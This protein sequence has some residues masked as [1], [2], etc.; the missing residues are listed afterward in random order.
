M[1]IPAQEQLP[2]YRRKSKGGLL[3]LFG[4]NKST[5]KSNQ[6]FATL[7]GGENSQKSMMTSHILESSQNRAPL[8]VQQVRVSSPLPTVSSTTLQ[9]GTSKTTLKSKLDKDPLVRTLASWD[10]PE[11][12]KAYP[13]AI[14]HARLRAPTAQIKTILQLYEE[15]KTANLEQDV[16]QNIALDH[17]RDEGARK[18]REKAKR[19]RHSSL[20]I[21]SKDGWVEKVYV[22]ATSGYLLEYAGDGAFDRLPEKLMHLGRESA[23]FASDAITGEHWVLQVSRI[24][25]D[26]GV[27]PDEGPKSI[28]RKLG[29]GSGMRRSTS[30]FLLT[31]DS[32]EDM[33]SW[34]VAIRK[35]IEALGGR[36]YRPDVGMRRTNDEI[37]R[38]LR[39]RPS[40]RYFIQREPNHFGDKLPDARLE[41][42]TDKEQWVKPRNLESLTITGRKPSIATQKSTE[43]PS[44][45]NA[46]VSTDQAFLERLKETPRISYVSAGTKTWS[47]SRGSSPEP[48]PAR[49]PF[50]P[51][52]LIPK[53]VEDNTETLQILRARPSS[54]RF[55]ASIPIVSKKHSMDVERG[56][57]PSRAFSMVQPSAD[58][59][60]P[61]PLPNFNVPSFSKRYSCVTNPTLMSPKTSGSNTNEFRAPPLTDSN[62]HHKSPKQPRL[63]VEEKPH[64]SELI[65]QSSPLAISRSSDIYNTS[66]LLHSLT[67]SEDNSLHPKSDHLVSRRF[68]SLDYT[69]DVSRDSE[70]AQSSFPH[71]PPMTA[72]PALP[73]HQI[74]SFSPENHIQDQRTK[75]GNAENIGK[76][77]RPVSMQVH[78]DPTTRSRYRPPK[79]GLQHP[80]EIDEHSLS[81]PITTIPKPRRAPPPPP[82][83]LV[84]APQVRN[85]QSAS[86]ATRPLLGDPLPELPLLAEI[87]SFLNLEN[88][89]LGSLE[90]PWN[91]SYA[92]SSQDM[93]VK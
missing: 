82:L 2:P 44:V 11:L 27:I 17:A 53:P 45:S 22:L 87:P 23:A 68:S 66:S 3:W 55:P 9:H 65:P 86:Q 57:G 31:F 79:I 26:D 4:R 58:R 6:K 50:S 72:L 52:D 54:Q 60:S 19:F 47:T 83:S 63:S 64:L 13:Q 80:S 7:E 71:P 42:M 48:S 37:A 75:S 34:L 35:E 12:F 91:S 36:K 84:Q 85:Y 14:K 20:E 78:S 67:N 15:K 88:S 49:A 56:T 10:P 59:A 24:A 73:R 32:P 92:G 51:E 70:S 16:E 93:R 28:F 40:R 33:N 46:T 39:E 74:Q 29:F 69:R 18:K 25:N 77:R 1:H 61:P 81:T 90:G 62:E 21:T 8:P 5:T 89:P 30:A 76:K 38:Q 43:S 41:D